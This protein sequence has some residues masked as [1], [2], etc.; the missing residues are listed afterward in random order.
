VGEKTILS[1]EPEVIA[2]IRKLAPGRL[3][4]AILALVRRSGNRTLRMV[5]PNLNETFD[6]G[7]TVGWV[8]AQSTT[9]TVITVERERLLVVS[10]EWRSSRRH[11]EVNEEQPQGFGAR[12]E[13]PQEFQNQF[14]TG[15]ARQ[16][17]ED[18]TT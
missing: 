11:A 2:M 6:P 16:I 9:R 7:S 3:S 1:Q 4:R 13:A 14:S 8:P 15:L 17:K 10:S 12:D 5:R 18:R